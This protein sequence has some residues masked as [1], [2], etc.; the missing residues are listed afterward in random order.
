MDVLSWA[1]ARQLGIER[2]LLARRV[3]REVWQ[4]VGPRVV[5]LHNGPLSREQQF[6]VGVLHAGR[7]GALFGP[8]ALEAHGL[9][10]FE[11]TPVHVVAAHGHG[12]RRLNHERIQ[13]VVHESLHLGSEAIHPAKRPRLQRVER[14]TV[15]AAATARND[16]RA[17]AF[18]AASVQQRLTTPALLRPYPTRTTTL[19][20]RRLILETI[21]DVTGGA[22]SL[23]EPEWQRGI[24]RFGLPRPKRQR[25]VRHA[26]GFY[27]LDCDFDPWLVTVEINGAQHLDLLTRE[28]DDHRRFTLSAEGRLVID[29][30]SHLV[31]HDIAAA[32]LRAARGLHSRGW[33]PEEMVRQRLERLAA[34]RREPLWLPGLSVPDRAPAS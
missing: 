13:V 26:S 20:R 5:V 24:R 21:D 15:D 33:E 6:W 18:I 30:S 23:P 28:A 25:I 34:S 16:D 12:R 7:D 4:L 10:R 2:H 27:Y 1:Q 31:R 9:K 22:H 29:I 11:V 14:A 32:I 3:A 17:R 19:P 8:T